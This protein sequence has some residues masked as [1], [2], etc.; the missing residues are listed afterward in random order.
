MVAEFLPT[1]SPATA[2]T[3][4]TCSAT[5]LTHRHALAFGQQCR[6]RCLHRKVLLS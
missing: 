2:M 3:F 6:Y 4:N 1:S 5:Y